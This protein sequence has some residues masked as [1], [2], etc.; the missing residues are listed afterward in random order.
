MTNVLKY[1]LIGRNI[2]HSLSPDY[3]K[4]KFRREGIKADYLLF[5]IDTVDEIKAIL[6]AHPTLK[7][8]NVTIPYKKKIYNFLNRLSPEAEAVGAVNTVKITKAGLEGFNTDIAGFRASFI[9]LVKGRLPL[10][11]LVLGTGGASRAVGFVLKELSIPYQLVSRVRRKNTITYSDISKNL[12]KDYRIIINTTPLGMF[13]NID[14][15]PMIP[16]H[17]LSKEHILY[18]LIYNPQETLF[19]KEGRRAGATTKNGLEMLH[20]QAEASWQIWQQ[21]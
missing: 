9:P 10:K 7:G 4:K 20:L 19:L 2:S 17:H 21:G 18:D 5:D 8:F 13:P 11:A 16:Y 3:F 14:K 12:L 1:G 15:A 6:K